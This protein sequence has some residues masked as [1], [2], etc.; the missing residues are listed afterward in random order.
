MTATSSPLEPPSAD[1]D[2]LATTLGHAFVHPELLAEALNHRSY[3]N[4]AQ[5]AGLV[6]NERLEF[7][8][9]AVLGMVSADLLFR[10][11]PTASEGDLS[12]HRSALVRAS[13]LAGFA[14]SIGLGAYLRLGRSEETTGGRDR[15]VLLAA[16]FEAVI[17]SLYLDGGLQA[18]VCFVEPL[19]RA[20]LAA[21]L[22]RPRLKDDKSLL[23][24]LAQGRLGV[25]PRYR[26]ATESGP[27]HER[28]FEVEVLFGELVLGRGSG[29]NKREAEQAA[30]AAALADPGWQE[31][32]GA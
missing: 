31:T 29:R 7:L 26:V 19:L 14:R 3:L 20:D 1:L 11:L 15:S 5:I 8:G 2:P 28:T 16:A 17:G 10:V 24:E 21:L 30:A 6:A 32:P 9:D 25:T 27:S 23:Q 12:E 13:A 4:E 18:V 22:T